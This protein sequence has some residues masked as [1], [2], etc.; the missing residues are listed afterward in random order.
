MVRLV[1]LDLL[2]LLWVFQCSCMLSNVYSSWYFTY[3]YQLFDLDWLP[4]FGSITGTCWRE[5][6]T[7]TTG[8]FWL[9]G[10]FIFSSNP[11]YTSLE[12]HKE[13]IQWPFPKTGILVWFI[14][15][16]H[17]INPFAVVWQGLPGP[18]GSPGEAGKPGDQVSGLNRTYYLFHLEVLYRLH[19]TTSYQSILTLP[20]HKQYICRIK[21]SKRKR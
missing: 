5:R 8:T 20:E 21:A 6:R 16:V 17:I 18:P 4:V 7:R 3:I 14:L 2:A 10:E 1:L 19:S 9:P 11:R 13:I 12:N 15:E